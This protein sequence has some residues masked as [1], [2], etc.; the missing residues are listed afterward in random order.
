M[1]RGPSSTLGVSRRIKTQDR[2]WE[3]IQLQHLRPGLPHQ[4]LPQQAP[5]PSSQNPEGPRS[6]G[7]R[8]KWAGPLLG[9]S[10]LSSTKHVSAGVIWFPDSPVCICLFTGGCWSRSKWIGL[11]REMRRWL[12]VCLF[13]FGQSRV[14]HRTVLNLGITL[15]QDFTYL[16]F[17]LLCIQYFCQ[18]L[19]YDSYFFYLFRV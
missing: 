3:K 5:A 12:I 13:F 2:S 14:A 9:L 19:P 1:Q 10:L 7:L 17:M 16:W 11:W 4:V 15:P 6:F 18:R 8:V